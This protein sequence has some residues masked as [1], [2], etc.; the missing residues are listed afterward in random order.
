MMVHAHI[1]NLW[2]AQAG[3][4]QILGQIGLHSENLTQKQKQNKVPDNNST[5]YS[6]LNFHWS[7]IFWNLIGYL[8]KKLPFKWNSEHRCFGGK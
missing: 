4:L 6:E 7:W 5:W 3:E 8:A 1:S 2:E